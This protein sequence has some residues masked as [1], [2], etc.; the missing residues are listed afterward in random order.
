[1]DGVLA[2]TSFLISLAKPQERNHVAALA[3]FKACLERGVPLYLS[4]IVVAEFSIK[5]S[6]LDLELRN[7]IGLPFNIDHAMKAGQI[8]NLLDR[9]ADD[10][11]SV[12]KDDVKL[13]AQCACES[14]ISHLLTGDERLAKRLRAL[15]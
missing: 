12:V 6:V 1:M 14:G 2:D 5:Q 7:F 10:A 8:W 3:Y 9:Q 13:I 4:T 15:S 11:K